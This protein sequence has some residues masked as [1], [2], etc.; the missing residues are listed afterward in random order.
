M[1]DLNKVVENRIK[2]AI[3]TN[4]MRLGIPKSDVY[5][6]IGGNGAIGP[7]VATNPET[8]EQAFMGFQPIWNIQI[9]LRSVLLKQDP[10]VGGLPIPSVFP[11]AQEIEFVVARLLEELQ[12]MR[13]NQNTVPK[14][15]VK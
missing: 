9:G 6:G 1:Q 14:L 8:N 13:D 4:C 7:L 11:A 15:E 10:L 5:Y 3:A 12:Q 2:D